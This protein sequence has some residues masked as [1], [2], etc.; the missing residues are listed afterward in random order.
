MTRYLAAPTAIL[1]EPPAKLDA[2]GRPSRGAYAQFEWELPHRMN[3]VSDW[4]VLLR[5]QFG[6]IV[7][8]RADLSKYATRVALA[9]NVPDLH[10]GS[11]RDGS[12]AQCSPGI[13]TNARGSAPSLTGFTRCSI[14]PGVIKAVTF[15]ADGTLWDFERVMRESLTLA[16]DALRSHA[17]RE[18]GTLSVDDLIRIRDRVAS[19]DSMLGAT[20]EQI[21]LVAFERTLEEIELC[22]S[23]LAARLNDLYMRHRFGGIRPFD[24]VAPTLDAL[25]GYR[26]GILSNGNSY[27]DRCGLPDRFQFTVFAHDHGGKKPDRHLFELAVRLA[28]C[29][30]EEIVHVGDSLKEDVA[31][32][33]SLGIRTAWINRTR[34]PNETDIRPD[35]ELHSL[36]DLLPLCRRETLASG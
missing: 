26:L 20:H 34:R 22:D 18:A 16:L 25:A 31:G 5:R 29:Q 21:R 14:V 28:G 7:S 12:P 8:R 1:R 4:R 11:Y 35:F 3:E 27:P 33:Q 13:G 24:D 15:D 23:N 32:A 10:L 36:T 17:P 2:A 30:P 9:Q 19:D 6:R